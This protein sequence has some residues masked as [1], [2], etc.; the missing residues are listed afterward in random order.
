V[1]GR[2][3][4]GCACGRGQ[5][6]LCREEVPYAG[7]SAAATR[8]RS[9]WRREYVLTGRQHAWTGEVGRTEPRSTAATFLSI[10][11]DRFALVT[12]SHDISASQW[13]TI[14]TRPNGSRSN[15]LADKAS[16]ALLA[17]SGR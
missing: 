11:T 3:P 13:R 7:H 8:C 17:L 4:D 14:P 9:M 1:P 2:G 15:S 16:S 6:A 12:F 5:E 10:G